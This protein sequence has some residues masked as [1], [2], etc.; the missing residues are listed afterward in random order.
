MSY[1]LHFY[2]T[3]LSYDLKY[4]LIELPASRTSF[5]YQNNNKLS[6]ISIATY[7][8]GGHFIQSLFHSNCAYGEE[9]DI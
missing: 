1:S 6:E 2:S 7:F 9:L 8:S 4:L 5:H 3:C